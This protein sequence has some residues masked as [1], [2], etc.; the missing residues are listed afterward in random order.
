MPQN[1]KGGPE[2]IALFIYRIA[3]EDIQTWIFFPFC[4]YFLKMDKSCKYFLY[5]ERKK[6]ICQVPTYLNDLLKVV[7][8][9]EM[10]SHEIDNVK[11]L[12]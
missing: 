2:E 12:L 10:S 9:H 1:Y 3:C 6:L 4:F 5:G 7:S 11:R 8:P